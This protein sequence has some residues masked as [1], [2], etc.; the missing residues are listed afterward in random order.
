M[1]R[2]IMQ[3]RT[4][5]AGESSSK[6]GSVTQ[7]TAQ[8]PTQVG[9]ALQVFHNLGALKDTI[10]NVVDGYCTGLEENI[11]NALDIKVLTQPSQTVTRGLAQTQVGIRYHPK[12]PHWPG[13]VLLAGNTEWV[14]NPLQNRGDG[15]I[16]SQGFPESGASRLSMDWAQAWPKLTVFQSF[17]QLLQHLLL[18]CHLFICAFPI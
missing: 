16:I 11:K 14:E 5:L 10:A 6:E 4:V 12:D 7:I 9:T 13:V 2:R 3:S 15:N 17:T 18:R 8:Y 1:P